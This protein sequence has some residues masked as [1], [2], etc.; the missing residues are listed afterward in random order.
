MIYRLK[1]GVSESTIDRE[2]GYITTEYIP[3]KFSKIIEVP[4][5]E[6]PTLDN[7]LKQR[8]K[9]LNFKRRFKMKCT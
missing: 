7:I 9:T 4:I 8:F 3:G 1:Q 2:C 5:E 6:L